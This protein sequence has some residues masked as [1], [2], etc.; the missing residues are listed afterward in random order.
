MAYSIQQ[1]KKDKKVVNKNI[2]NATKSSKEVSERAAWL[3]KTRN[4]PAAKAGFSEDD[5]WALQK[6]HRASQ[7]A[8]K[9]PKATTK[10]KTTTKSSSKSSS[11][12]GPSWVDK[13]QAKMP[14]N[15]K[16]KNPDGSNKTTK[17]SKL[18]VNKKRARKFNKNSRR[19][20]PFLD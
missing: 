7:A 19:K 17:K 1:R 9:K 8:R 20:N 14:W 13:V 16:Y 5:R 15:K 18:E 10:S 6:K 2:K 3:K 12:K 4:S 11:T